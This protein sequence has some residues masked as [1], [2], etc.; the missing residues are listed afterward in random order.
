MST[1]IVGNEPITTASCAICS[2]F[3]YFEP[4]FYSEM[5]NPISHL[6]DAI[7]VPFIFFHWSVNDDTC[8]LTQMEMAITGNDKDETFFGRVMGPIYKMDDTDANNLL[9]T[10]LF[11]LW[12]LVQFRLGRVDLSPLYSKK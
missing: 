5:Y 10:L 11:A 3:Y 9:K 2:F 6:L 1:V 4:D 8:A 7:L 12:S